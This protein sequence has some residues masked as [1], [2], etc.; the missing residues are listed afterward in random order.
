M[1]CEERSNSLDAKAVA[2]HLLYKTS[3][4]S[5]SDDSAVAHT[6]LSRS[7]HMWSNR[8]AILDTELCAKTQI[9]GNDFRGE[10]RRSKHQSSLLLNLPFEIREKIHEQFC[11]HT[12]CAKLLQN[13]SLGDNSE[14]AYDVPCTGMTDILFYNKDNG[15]YFFIL[16]DRS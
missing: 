4:G 8:F 10:H 9:V 14:E 2:A 12:D 11:F 13:R 15:P 3:A 16:S 6:L 7:W 1:Y 5:G